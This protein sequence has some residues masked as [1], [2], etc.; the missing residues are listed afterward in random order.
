MCDWV[1]HCWTEINLDG[2]IYVCD[3]EMEGIYGK[4][5]DV[6]WDLFMVTHEE[7]PIE[8]VPW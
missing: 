6:S 4:N 1:W 2:E 3:A 7:A 5:H 8:Y